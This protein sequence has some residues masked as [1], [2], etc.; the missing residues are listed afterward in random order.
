VITTH[1]YTDIFAQYLREKGWNART[2]KTDYQ[3][4][5]LETDKE[6]AL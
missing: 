1:G 6:T 2:E 5:V 4:E 3:G